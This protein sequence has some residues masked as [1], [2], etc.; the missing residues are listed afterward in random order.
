MTKCTNVITEGL[1][2]TSSPR[3]VYT[4]QPNPENQYPKLVERNAK[5]EKKDR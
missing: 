2:I 5:G 3:N 4:P 1:E